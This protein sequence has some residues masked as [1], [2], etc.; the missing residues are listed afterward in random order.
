MKDLAPDEAR[1]PGRSFGDPGKPLGQDIVERAADRS[2]A[3]NDSGVYGGRPS[4]LSGGGTAGVAERAKAVAVLRKAEEFMATEDPAPDGPEGMRRALELAAG[5]VG[6]TLDEYDAI[7]K[8]DP[9]LAELERKVLAAA[10][11]V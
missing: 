9:E 5:R 2:A 6:T 7:V 11:D 1:K 4:Q 8:G 3:V 10:K